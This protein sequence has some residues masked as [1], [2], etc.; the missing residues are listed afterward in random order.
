MPMK[1]S[2]ILR[3]VFDAGGNRDSAIVRA[4]EMLE[5]RHDDLAASLADIDER[6][7]RLEDAAD[8]RRATRKAKS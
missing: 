8:D 1:A 7:G 4:V 2:E 6:I 3:N 5:R